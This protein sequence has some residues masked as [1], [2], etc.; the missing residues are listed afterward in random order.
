MRK[1]IHNMKFEELAAYTLDLEEA[2]KDHEDNHDRAMTDGC[3]IN[4][5]LWDTLDGGENS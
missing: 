2:I 1:P 3:P 4:D 5:Q